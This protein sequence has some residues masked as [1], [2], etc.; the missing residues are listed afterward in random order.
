MA[1]AA[2]HPVRWRLLTDLAEGDLRVRELV[3]RTG[4]AQNVVSYHL[5]LLRDCGLVTARRSDADG[6]DSYYHLEL[7]RCSDALI[8]AGQ[9]LHPALRLARAPFEPPSEQRPA[10]PVLISVLFVCTGNSARSPIAEALAGVRAPG[11]LLTFSAGTAP[12]RSL[13]PELRSVLRDQHGID[14]TGRRPRSLADAP[15]SVDVLVTLCDKARE[16]TAGLQGPGHRTHWSLPDPAAAPGGSQA[17]RRALAAVAA[18]IETRVNHLVPAVLTGD[19]KA[20]A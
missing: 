9:L 1:T 10:R 20:I 16:A 5:R 17:A 13:H 2:G 4:E 15:G 3:E 12:K 19:R 8:G 11:R 18:E 14:W 7:E 6:R